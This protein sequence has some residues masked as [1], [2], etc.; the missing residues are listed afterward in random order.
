MD[1]APSLEPSTARPVGS[2]WT[3]VL[4]AVLGFFLFATSDAAI[5]TLTARYSIFQII[6]TQVAFATVPLALMVLR[7]GSWRSLVPLFPR[8]V[9][10]RG[11]LAGV[12]TILVY[13][14]FGQLPLAEVY[15]ISFCIPI[16]V[17]ILSIPVLGEKVGVHRWSAVVVGFVGVLVMIQP[18]PATLTTGHLAAFLAACG[19]AVITMILRRLAGH[20]RSPALVLSVVLGL[21][22]VSLPPALLTS[23]LPALADLGLMA[24]TGLLMGTAQFVMLQAFRRAPAASV[25]PMQYTM[26]LWAL[27]YGVALFG[28]PIRA[29]VLA[30]A[31]VVIASSLYILHR[32]RVRRGTRQT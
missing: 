13:H 30:G 8:A 12:G 22:V 27:G 15:A 23:R 25:A 16:L 4:L 19:G 7:A 6:A 3:G 31:A 32:E 20:E 29:H 18:S 21:L 9:A 10:V 5:K 11:L 14:A 17:T 28:D 26:M 1:D 24:A 2:A